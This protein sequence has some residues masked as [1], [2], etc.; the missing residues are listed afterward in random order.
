MAC[1]YLFG[2]FIFN[3]KRGCKFCQL[4]G[5]KFDFIGVIL[6]ELKHKKA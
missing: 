4:W 2:Y 6:G 3:L 1:V 5:E